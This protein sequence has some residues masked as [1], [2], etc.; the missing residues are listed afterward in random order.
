MTEA[1]SR[2]ETLILK[3]NRLVISAIAEDPECAAYSGCS[4]QLSGRNIQFRQAKSTPKKSGQFVTLWKRNHKG[5]TEPFNV[6]DDFDFY[7]IAAGQQ[8]RFGFFLFPKY[9]LGE[10]QIL[11]TS[12][13]EGKR[14]FR[15]YADWDIVPNRQAEKTKAWQT[16]YFTDLTAP[17]HT[18][19][20]AFHS[21][22]NGY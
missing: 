9:L 20:K 14:G 10:K 3:S 22:I 18:D 1:L 15:I 21:I 7:M 16:R 8:H 19:P 13:K 6:M 17:E 4:F 5:Q 2:I 12:H 11:T